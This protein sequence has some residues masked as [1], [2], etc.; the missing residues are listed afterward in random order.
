MKVPP[1]P[2]IDISE[3]NYTCSVLR[4]EIVMYQSI[5]S[6]TIPLATP[7]DSHV[8]TARAVG[9]SPNFLCPGGLGTESWKFSTILKTNAGT[10]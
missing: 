9:F 6:L 2:G 5:P 1:S 3:R 7:V 4:L 8:P 10:S